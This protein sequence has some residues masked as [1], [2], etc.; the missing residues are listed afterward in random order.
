MR[1]LVVEDDRVSAELLE[2]FLT[3]NGYDVAVARNGREAFE[4]L[5][6]DD[7][8]VVISDWQMP[9]MSGIDLCRRVRQRQLSAYVYIILLTSLEGTRNLVQALE[10]GAD[11][12]LTKPFHPEEL[13]VRLRAAERIV[14]LESRDLVIFSLAK[15]AESRDPETGAHLERM[16]EYCRILADELSR[17]PKYAGQID[18]D[19]VRML[20]L[21]SPLHDV[22][23]VGIPDR[24]LLKPGKLDPDE[25]NVMKQHTVIGQE[26]LDAALAAHPTAEFLRFARDIAWTHHERYDGAGYPRQLRGEEIPL[27]GRIVAV[28]D[29]YDALT[30]KR[31]YKPAFS[32]EKSR[33]IILEGCGTQ[34]DP[35]IVAAFVAR[36]EDFIRVRQELDG[37]D[38][39]QAIVVSLYESL[40]PAAT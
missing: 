16:R 11:D 34:F 35:E 9:E 6:H 39:A 40:E 3:E 26:T 14:A 32:H 23:K 18:E 36:E 4:L 25:F 15:L 12:F 33:G 37:D 30:T 10:A 13:T 20:Y 2:L 7:F 21:T 31:V 27:C 28:A 19:Y 38:D 17:L 29:V 1:V 22:G 24:V 5:R 8:R